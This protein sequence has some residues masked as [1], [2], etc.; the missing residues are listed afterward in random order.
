MV[1][2]HYPEIIDN[3]VAEILQRE[4]NKLTFK[5]IVNEDIIKEVR[6]K[7]YRNFIIYVDANDNGIDK[8][9]SKEVTGVPT[10]LWAKVAKMNPMW[11]D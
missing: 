2:L 6:E 11:W 8:I 1:Y 10:T 7:I 3:V 4:K 9:D 5:P